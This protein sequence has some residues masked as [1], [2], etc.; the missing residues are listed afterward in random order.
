MAMITERS[1]PPTNRLRSEQVAALFQNVVPGVS[2][3][4]A[5]AIVLVSAMTSL[6]ALHQAV[7]IAWALYIVVCAGAHIALRYSYVRCKPD[8]LRWKFWADGFVAICLA[9]GIGWGW[10]SISL[11]G[12]SGQFSLEMVVMIVT[13]SVAAGSIP[14]FSAYLPAFFALFL[15]TTIPSLIWAIQTRT[16]FP[17][18]TVMCSMMAIFVTGMGAIGVRANRNFNELVRLRIDLQEQKEVAERASL[19]KSQFLAA[20]SHDLRQPVHAL[21]LFV[22]ALR[23]VSGL[24]TAA[25]RILD[26]MELSTT[27]MGDLFSAILD[28]SRLDAGVVEVRRQAFALQ[29][30]LDRVCQDFAEEAADKSIVLHQQAT[31]AVVF[32]DPHLVERILRNLVSNAIRHSDQGRLVV[33]CR[34]RGKAVRLEVWDTGAGITLENQKRIFQEYVQLHNPERDRTRGLG[35]GLAIVRRLSE[36]LDCELSLRSHVGRGSCFSICLPLAEVSPISSL[37]AT[38]VS[39][40]IAEGALILVIDDEVAV[41]EAMDA[42]LT[43]WGYS[44]LTAASGDEA[45][46]VL[47]Q[48][49]ENPRMIICDYRLRGEENGIDVIRLLQVECQQQVPAVLITGDTAE[50]R[51]IEAQASGLVLL[52]K[53]VHN[54]KLRAVIVNS[55]RISNQADVKP[56]LINAIK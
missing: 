9:E 23:A 25:L 17:E 10:A 28:I 47:A 12:S 2:A 51:L 43:G 48:G 36:L 1:L 20:A 33:G 49:K 37:A 16:M 38:E 24:P 19:A 21:G 18:A 13:L 56:E 50:D 42:L 3:A 15:P 29:P 55:M 54:S 53:P 4:A 31:S 7:G 8:S 35:L 22:S 32:S 11:A 30:L 27:A 34:K 6:G 52:H 44:V 5:S 46:T 26:R 41:R 45:L 39:H 40:V 14:V